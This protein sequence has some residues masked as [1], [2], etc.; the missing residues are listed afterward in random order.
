MPASGLELDQYRLYRVARRGHPL[1]ESEDA[2]AANPARGRFALADGASESYQSK[3]WAQ[4]LVE[5]FAAG[6]DLYPDWAGWLAPLQARW[7]AR[8]GGNGQ[9]ALPFYLASRL[10]QQ[11][12]FSTFLGIVVE[13]RALYARAVGDTCLFLVRGDNL[14]LAFPL[15]VAEDFTSRPWLIGSCTTPG[16]VACEHGT[17][18]EFD[19]RPGD[20]LWMMT[21]ALAQW[22]LT[23]KAEGRLPWR[24]LG[25][26][27]HGGEEAFPGWVDELRRDGRLKNDDVTVMGLLL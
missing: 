21:D 15:T 1:E 12:A 2:W 14:E 24:E 11:G 5:G 22:F 9:S 20:A 17:F 8:A 26:L 18:V 10:Q 6:T 13:G 19:Y 3:L 16:G 4:L 27:W 7:A 25:V 23:E